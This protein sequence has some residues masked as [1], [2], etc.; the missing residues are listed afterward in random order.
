MPLSLD[1]FD[2]ASHGSL[3]NS[4]N[5][6]VHE[7]ERYNYTSNSDNSTLPQKGYHHTHNITNRFLFSHNYNNSTPPIEVPSPPKLH[8]VH[9]W[10]RQRNQSATGGAYHMKDRHRRRKHHAW[11]TT[12]NSASQGAWG[13]IYGALPPPSGRAGESRPW[14]ANT[15]GNRPRPRNTCRG[16]RSLDAIRIRQQRRKTRRR[17]GRRISRR[18]NTSAVS[19]YPTGQETPNPQRRISNLSRSANSNSPKPFTLSR[20]EKRKEILNSFIYCDTIKE[21]SAHDAQLEIND[22]ET[23]PKMRIEHNKADIYSK[24]SFVGHKLEDWGKF[25]KKET[26][27]CFNKQAEWLA[28]QLNARSLATVEKR[29][30]IDTWA[31]K[32]KVDILIFQESKI[33]SNCVME[34]D[35]Y[36]WF[37]SSG[38]SNENRDKLDKAKTNN[39]KVPVDLR[40]A[41]TEHRGVC[42]AIYRG[43]KNMIEHVHACGD[44]LLHLVLRSTCKLHIVAAHAPTSPHDTTDKELFYKDLE[45]KILR[46]I[47]KHEMLIL[48]GDMNAKIIELSEEEEDIF[49]RHYLRAPEGKIETTS[50]KTLENR[51]LFLNFVRDNEPHICNTAFRK[52]IHKIATHKPIGTSRVSAPWDYM[53]FDQIDYLLVRCRWK[54]AVKKCETDTDSMI[55][56]DHYPLW[57]KIKIKFKKH[58]QRKPK[59]VKLDLTPPAGTK[60]KFNEEFTKFFSNHLEGPL[61]ENIDKAFATARTVLNT[62]TP[63][64]KKPWISEHTYSLIREKHVLEQ[65]NDPALGNKIKEVQRSKRNDWKKYT[66]SLVNEDMDIRDKWLGIKFLKQQRKPKLYEFANRHGQIVP[67]HERAEAMADYLENVQWACHSVEQLPHNDPLFFAPP[68]NPDTNKPVFRNKHTNAF[69]CAPFVLEELKTFLKKSKN[70]KACGPDA[71]PMEFIK[72]LNDANLDTILDFCNICWLE[73]DFPEEKMKAFVASIYKKGDPQNPANYRPISLL[74]SMYK[75]YA[76]LI[77]TRL[78]VA[79]DHDVADTQYGFRK[80]RS[81]SNAIACIRRLF[82]RAEATK[83]PLCV[84]FLDWEKAFDRVKPEKLLE[85]LERMSIPPTFMKAIASLYKNPTFAVNAENKQSEWKQQRA[86]I[87]QGCPL[88]PYLFVIVMTVIM[89]D[90]SEEENFNR[91]L[92]DGLSFTE[93]LYADDTVLLTTNVSTMNRLLAKVEKCANYHGLNFNKNKCVSVNFHTTARTKYADGSRVPTAE[94]ATYLGATLSKSAN[95]RKEVNAKISQC[96]VILNKLQ[97]FWK[98]PN[99]PSRFKIQ[100]YDAVI[101]SKLVYSLESLELTSGLLNH[102]NAFQLKGLRK[103]LNMKTTFVERA[104]TNQ[105]VMQRANAIKNPEGKPGKDIAPY[106]EYIHYKQNSLLAHIARTSTHDPLR[107]CTFTPGTNL[108]FQMGRKRVGRPRHNWT[109]QTYER[110]AKLN[111]PFLTNDEWKRNHYHYINLLQPKIADKTVKLK[112]D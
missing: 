58:A 31:N 89:R 39:H 63:E 18:V 85:A 5:Y 73:G 93:L 2:L 62:K 41:T 17:L 65:N 46:K 21:D 105:L 40:L 112:P 102:L 80:G 29:N 110:M 26:N 15:K 8:I 11:D 1:P 44:R 99:C 92:L 95:T 50:P 94:Q 33:N 69:N 19:I 70:R 76:G 107:Q 20:R 83:D 30:S 77:Q 23:M 75:I 13:N 97:Y 90:V 60:S 22:G 74:S 59:N 10:W 88:S 79:L 68:I 57:S 34:T 64:I 96:F 91:G 100:V 111:N 53:H 108:P 38:V 72:F 16:F 52:Q 47:P 9:P 87:R 78:M 61:W 81:T 106:S 6:D 35:N 98:N 82:D 84:T 56:S 51:R 55:D 4:G 66:D 25:V 103:I 37:F 48:G 24:Y 86:G 43:Y 71:I 28:V 32:H 54:N 45:S 49:G 101:R 3:D 109:V 36:I 12:H 104:N 67:G 14:P 27:A 42:I 7:C